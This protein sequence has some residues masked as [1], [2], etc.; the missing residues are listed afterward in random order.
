MVVRGSFDRYCRFT[1]WF[2]YCRRKFVPGRKFTMGNG[3]A[4]N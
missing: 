2:R 4:R 3:K 1:P